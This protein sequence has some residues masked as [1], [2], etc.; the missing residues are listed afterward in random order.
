V[1]NEYVMSVVT[2]LASGVCQQ[3]EVDQACCPLNFK[4]NLFTTAAV[5]NSDHNPSST[6]AHGSFHGTGISLQQ[7]PGLTASGSE[8]SLHHAFLTTSKVCVCACCLP[9][10]LSAT[11]SIVD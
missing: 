3:F 7:H 2:D 6:N 10:L 11:R 1:S 9:P 4:G 5:D 8:R